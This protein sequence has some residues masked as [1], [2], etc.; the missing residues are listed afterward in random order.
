MA[1]DRGDL[2]PDQIEN[3]VLMLCLGQAGELYGERARSGAAALGDANQGAEDRRQGSV[4]GQG[5][6]G[7]GLDRDGQW[8]RATAVQGGVKELQAPLLREGFDAT[9]PHPRRVALGQGGDHPALSL[10]GAPG[11]RGGGQAF[12]LALL[13]ERV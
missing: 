1:E 6:G 7:G 12:C 13:G 5:P 2:R 4:R 11:D 9:A 3:E 10:P 8:L